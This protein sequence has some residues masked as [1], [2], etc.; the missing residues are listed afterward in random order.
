VRRFTFPLL[1][2]AACLSIP[3]LY[4]QSML[5]HHL[6]EDVRSGRAQ[7]VGHLPADQIMNLNIVLPLSDP[8]G[9]D[10]FLAALYDPK[11]ASY[12]HFLTVS[13][14][15]ARFGPTQVQYDAVVNF[16]K[17]NG[18]TVIGGSRDGMNVEVRGPV[19]A[20]ETA[21]RIHMQNYQHPNEAAPS[22]RQIPNQQPTFPS[23]SGTSPASTT[24]PS[25]TRCS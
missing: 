19:S 4:A 5:T 18:F 16:A 21:F 14:F 12:R 25:R 11:S 23:T 17:L 7:S 20:V 22:T 13:E 9:L 24:S 10:N 8:A 2:L 15:T 1:T 6:R 3:A